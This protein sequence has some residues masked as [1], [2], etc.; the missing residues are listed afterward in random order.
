MESTQTLERCCRFGGAQARS[1]SDDFIIR[2]DSLLTV[3]RH[4]YDLLVVLTTNL[5]NEV[6]CVGS[7]R[8]R[9]LV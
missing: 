1:V 8:S 2:Y 7:I 9:S 6:S 5:L 4:L 3:L